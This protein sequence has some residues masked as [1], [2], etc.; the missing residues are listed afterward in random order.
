MDETKRTSVSITFENLE[1]TN[2]VG[3]SESDYL[4]ALKRQL[5]VNDPS[6]KFGSR[7]QAYLSGNQYATLPVTLEYEGM[8]VRQTYYVRAQGKYMIGVLVTL[9]DTEISTVEAMFSK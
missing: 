4:H 3:L 1:T 8:V 2:N 5:T 7:G 6:C 9:V